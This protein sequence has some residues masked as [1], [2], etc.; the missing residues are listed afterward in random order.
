MH[1]SISK[2]TLCQ[3]IQ[4]VGHAIS[5]NSPQA[6]LRGILL[7]CKDNT[8][9]LTGSDADISIQINLEPNEENNLNI[10]EE[11]KILIDNKYLNEI[12]KKIDSDIINLEI[13]DGSLTKIS[14]EKVVYKINGMFANDY[15]VIDFSKPE[16]EFSVFAY[17]LTSI[18]EQTSFA[19]AP[20]ETRPVLTGV[21]FNLENNVLHC[22]A[23]DSYRLAKKLMPLNYE[24]NFNV[25]IPD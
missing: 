17:Q 2:D 1:F 22:T 7:T 19:T 16:N 5:S 9:T 11:G 25:T 21:N 3:S 6:S 12:S 24:N 18:I 10:Y 13:I 15:P 4:I 14:G 8:L 23:T 20:K